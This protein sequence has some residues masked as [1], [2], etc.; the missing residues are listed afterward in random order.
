MWEACLLA[1]ALATG[2][3]GAP[4]LLPARLE[5]REEPVSGMPGRDDWAI[6]S[7][8]STEDSCATRACSRGR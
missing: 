5:R 3:G 4:V 6:I 7:C 8:P 1:A 2:G